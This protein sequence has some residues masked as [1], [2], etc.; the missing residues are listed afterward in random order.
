MKKVMSNVYKRVIGKEYVERVEK[1]RTY[2]N[3][4][5][6]SPF[7]KELKTEKDVRKPI[8][9][10]NIIRKNPAISNHLF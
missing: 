5:Y 6:N 1:M 4:F 8:L 10:T 7:M 2:V 9:Q 3:Y